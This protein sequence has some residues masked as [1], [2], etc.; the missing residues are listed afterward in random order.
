MLLVATIGVTFAYF[1]SSSQNDNAGINAET[2]ELGKSYKTL[3]YGSSLII[4]SLVLLNTPII[5]HSSPV[6]DTKNATTSLVGTTDF[7]M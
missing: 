4:L 3:Q 7:G 5:L 2:E 6:N 1:A